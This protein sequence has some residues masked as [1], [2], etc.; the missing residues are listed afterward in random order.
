MWGTDHLSSVEPHGLL[1]L[2][3]GIRDLEVCLGDG[4]IGISDCEKP[5]KD[6]LRK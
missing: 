2:V 5:F 3:R 6:K 1:K 4:I